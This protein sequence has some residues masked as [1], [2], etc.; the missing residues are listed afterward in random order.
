MI[1]LE[2]VIGN[3]LAVEEGE[4]V[5]FSFRVPFEYQQTEIQ[6]FHFNSEVCKRGKILSCV[7][8]L[9]LHATGLLNYV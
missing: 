9:R 6:A 1:N 4:Q 7:E 2:N 5:I 3:I 8:G